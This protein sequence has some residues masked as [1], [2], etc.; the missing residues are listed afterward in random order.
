MQVQH[1]DFIVNF[2]LLH[3][4]KEAFFHCLNLGE[5]VENFSEQSSRRFS[6]TVSAY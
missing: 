6:S 4:F 1:N 3:N 5:K 2:I